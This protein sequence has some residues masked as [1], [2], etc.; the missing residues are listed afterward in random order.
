MNELYKISSQE[1]PDCYEPHIISFNNSLLLTYFVKN[2][3]DDTYFLKCIFPFENNR[4]LTINYSAKELQKP[5]IISYP[6]LL[7]ISLT[8]EYTMYVDS[9]FNITNDLQQNEVLSKETASLRDTITRLQKESEE[10]SAI[11]ESIK[12]QYNQL[13]D[14]AIKCRDEAIKWRSKFTSSKYPMYE[15]QLRSDLASHMLQDDI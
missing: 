8:P 4:T 6:D 7:I 12:V 2:M 3:L 13:M 1:L 15:Q 9:D 14:T 5:N 10:K 11:I